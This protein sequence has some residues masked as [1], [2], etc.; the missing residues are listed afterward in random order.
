MRDI[1]VLKVERI[2]HGFNPS[3]PSDHTERDVECAIEII[4]KKV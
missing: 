1:E 4:L 3:D 2:T